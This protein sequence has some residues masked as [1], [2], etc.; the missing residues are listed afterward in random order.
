MG[1]LVSG[2]N[3]YEIPFRP[4]FELHAASWWGGA[5]AMTIPF[6][7]IAHAPYGMAALTTTGCAVMAALR[8]SQGY[9]KYADRKN[10]N[11]YE[12]SFINLQGVAD[13]MDRESIWLGDGFVWDKEAANKAYEV[14]RRGPDH[15]KTKKQKKNDPK[16]GAIWLQNLKKNEDLRVEIKGLEG[17]TLIAGTTGAGKTRLLDIIVSQ[18][19]M[20]G[21]GPVVVID[22][23]GDKEL[24]ENMRRACVGLGTPER[25]VVFDPAHAKT[26]CRIDPCRNW[27]RST[28]IPSRIT[29]MMNG[30]ASD[31]F[32]DIAWNALNTGVQGMNFIGENP[33]LRKI[34]EFIEVGAGPLLK[35]VLQH[36]FAE[37][38]PD[39]EAQ[40]ANAG[41]T[42]KGGG[43]STGAPSQEEVLLRMV[44]FYKN[45]VKV[46]KPDATV[47]ALIT[48][49]T[50]DR[51]HFQKLIASLIPILAMLTSDVLGDLL[52]PDYGDIDDPREILDFG[53]A[54]RDNRVV[55]VALDSLSDGTVASAVGSIML[56]DLAAVAGKIYN[57]EGKTRPI[58]LVIDEASEVINDPAI[59]ILNKGRGAGF[60]TYIATQ[61]VSD[62]EARLGTKPSALQALGNVNNI[63]TL[64]IIDPGTQEYITAQFPKFYVES[65]TTSHKESTG[66]FGAI[67]TDRAGYS[68]SLDQEY[69]PL[70]EPSVLGS[71]P[72]LEYMAKLKDGRVL[73]GRIPIV[74]AKAA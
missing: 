47:D 55:Y 48:L 16:Q 41:S 10:L 63:I 65:M 17:H 6:A 34:R 3:N 22:P 26:S 56:A 57:Y 29:D 68:E 30:G 44:E 7:M 69:L 12:R 24:Q 45:K 70:I 52:S 25:F 51:E 37:W 61:T 64:R 72:D 60:Q 50:H 74:T 21:D 5:A 14:L 54:I 43:K 40:F 18:L 67:D 62:F 2:V 46:D 42:E 28:E 1:F 8:F 53:R 32:K 27:S 4:P 11:N 31:P 36:H 59:R 71:I 33:S 23:K 66:Q 49:H 73:K 38:A 19:I 15:Y 9:S 20:R 39:W 13:H 35:Q 58:Y